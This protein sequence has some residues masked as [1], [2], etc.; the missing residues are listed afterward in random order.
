MMQESVYLSLMPVIPAAQTRSMQGQPR[1]RL[2]IHR[3]AKTMTTARKR[4]SVEVVSVV[5]CFTVARHRLIVTK[6]RCV[7]PKAGYA[8]RRVKRMPIAP[9]KPDALTLVCV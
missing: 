1:C 7:R 4:M 8:L 5:L 9:N 3:I 6:G 2:Q